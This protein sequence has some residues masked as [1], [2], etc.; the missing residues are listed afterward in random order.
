[1]IDLRE[2]KGKLKKELKEVIEGDLGY[3]F[4]EYTEN[5]PVVFEDKEELEENYLEIAEEC[6][7][8][9]NLLNY[10]NTEKMIEDDRMSGYLYE[11]EKGRW[12]RIY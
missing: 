7:C 9:K 6:G 2:V 5:E 8:P 4:N 10:L 1:M 3:S 11:D 12:F